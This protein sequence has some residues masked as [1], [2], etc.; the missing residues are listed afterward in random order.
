MLLL[1][2]RDDQPAILLVEV[3][4]ATQVHPVVC[5]LRTHDA[6]LNDQ[7]V[8]RPQMDGQRVDLLDIGAAVD[9]LAADL[10]MMSI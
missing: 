5:L 10:T 6:Y 2:P 7:V 8:L 4:D 9:A 3:E 1:G